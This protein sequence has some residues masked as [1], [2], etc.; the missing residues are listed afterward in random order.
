MKSKSLLYLCLAILC[1]APA[2][3]HAQASVSTLVAVEENG[4]RSK[5]LNF[6]YLSDGFTTAEM[7]TFASEV[8]RAVDYLFNRE[9]W[10]RYRKFCNVYRIEVPSA[11]SGTSDPDNGVKKNTYFQSYFWPGIDRLNV[12]SGTGEARAYSIMNAFVPE[13]DVPVVIVNTARY[14]GSGG[15]IAVATR[16]DSGPGLVEHETGHSFAGLGDEYQTPTPGYSQFEWPNTTAQPDIEKVRWKIWVEPGTPSKTPENHPLWEDKVGHFEGANYSDTGQFRAHDASIMQFLSVPN[17]GQVNREAFVLGMYKRVQLLNGYSP[18]ALTQTYTMPTALTLNVSPKEILTAPLATVTWQHNGVTLPGETG[19]SLVKN[20]RDFGNGTHKIKAIV[21]DPTDWIRKPTTALV[22]EVTWTLNLSKQESDPPVITTPLPASRVL[23]VGGSLML[24]ATATGPGPITYQ[25]LRNNAPFKPAITTPTLN[26]G[27]VGL[28]D[29]GTLSVKISNSV[30]TVTHTCVLAV[31]DPS[32]PRVIAAKGKTATLAFAASTNL[33]AVEW[34]QGEA[35]ITNGTHYANAT[36][37]ALQIKNVDTFD[38]GP[39]YFFAGDYGPSPDI[40]LLVVTGKPEYPGAP[41]TLPPG[42]VGGAYDQPFPLPPDELRTPNSFAATLH[43]GLKI[44]AKTGRITGRPTVASKDKTLGDEITFTVGNEF[45]KVPVKIRLKIKPLPPGISGLFSGFIQSGS[46]LGDSTGGRIDLNVMSTGSFSGSAII[47]PD[48]LP[49]SGL[50]SVVNPDASSATGSF[51]VKPKHTPT[52]VTVA[53]VIDDAGDADPL[54]ASATANPGYFYAWRN[55][56]LPPEAVDTFKGYYTFAFLVP[57]QGNAPKGR[58]FGSVTIDAT[59][60]SVVSGRLADG[61]TFATTS[62]VDPDGLLLI[63][64]TLYTT[65]AK[66]SFLGLLDLDPGPSGALF[67]NASQTVWFRPADTRPATRTYAAGFGPLSV[68]VVGGLY[69]PPAKDARILGLPAASGSP[70]TNALLGFDTTLGDDPLP[71][72]ADVSLEVKVGGTTKVNTPNPKAVTFSVT[73]LDGRFKGIYTTKDNDP[74]PPLTAAP[75]P[76][77]SRK[78]DYQGIIVQDG[79]VLKGH[80]FFLRD[81]LPKADGSTTPLTSPKHS[82][83]LLLQT[84]DE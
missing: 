79:G 70:L 64:Q 77:I 23:A 24:D 10:S 30:H 19:S 54:T 71:V 41:P 43:A 68:G 47:G 15:P 38:S 51:T 12:L 46:P 7:G 72:N 58:G 36:T 66:G 48:T 60:K 78:V 55:K 33:P 34:G 29:A 4:P 27:P 84:S 37:K 83:K 65:T 14:G 20:T 22:Q 63:Y 39:Y 75:R 18:V 52:G 40:Q 28:A 35:T 42:I 3:L 82:G 53:F 1:L 67:A 50:L 17:I 26:L 44:D 57:A 16:H 56:W 32:V 73:P 81:A 9:P 31:L 25:W 6:V 13:Y 76:Q 11:E 5:Q 8:Q 2:A 45:G 61:E 80:G 59:G 74:R 49:F 69:T 62:H 21:R